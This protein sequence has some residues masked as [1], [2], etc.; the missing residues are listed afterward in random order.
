MDTKD[1]PLLEKLT[2]QDRKTVEETIEVHPELTA[3]TA[4][5]MLAEFGGLQMTTAEARKLT[6]G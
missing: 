2:P 1:D 3:V 6:G 4:I 5:E